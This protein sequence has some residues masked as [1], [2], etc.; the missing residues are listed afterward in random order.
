MK[1]TRTKLRKLIRE[2]LGDRRY[3]VDPTGVA[4]SAR[5]ARKSGMQRIS[6]DPI[7][8]Q[9][10]KHPDESYR[11]QAKELAL[12]ADLLPGEEATSIE[13]DPYAASDVSY[14]QEKFY[15]GMMKL[16]EALRSDDL[17]L[18]IIDISLPSA[19][20]ELPEYIDADADSIPAIIKIEIEQFDR[21]N[22]TISGYDVFEVYVYPS[23]GWY[24]YVEI[25]GGPGDLQG[26][27]IN[28]TG[29]YEND[30]EEIAK[31]IYSNQ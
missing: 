25:Y 23:D 5:D 6:D 19:T 31:I 20:K 17:S 22:Q 28:V 21:Y 24:G 2:A 18:N 8:S 4:T 1:L 16:I 10:A 26:N 13:M 27:A 29:N 15:P 3:I 7:L 14:A 12:S 9:L 30:A 11:N